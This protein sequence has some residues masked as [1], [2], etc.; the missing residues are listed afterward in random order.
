MVLLLL[1]FLSITI[2]R[3]NCA[4]LMYLCTCC[5]PIIMQIAVYLCLINSKP[6]ETEWCCFM[7]LIQRGSVTT[8]RIQL[9]LKLFAKLLGFG[10]QVVGSYQAVALLC[11]HGALRRQSLEPSC[12]K[13]VKRVQ[14][15]RSGRLRRSKAK[16]EAKPVRTCVHTKDCGHL[17]IYIYISVCVCVCVCVMRQYMAA[18]D[19]Y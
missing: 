6:L 11:K 17:N 4:V 3:L 9:Q 18:Q 13:R 15:V 14:S 2:L 16:C 19:V 10:Y 12:A 8:T 1:V 7:Q 5:M